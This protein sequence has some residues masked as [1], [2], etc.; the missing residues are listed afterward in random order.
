MFETRLR[1]IRKKQKLTLEDVAKRCTPPTTAQTI[2]RLETGMRTL[3]VNWIERIAGALKVDPQELIGIPEAGDIKVLAT[4][5]K[6]G[7][8]N[9][10]DELFSLR[11]SITNPVAVR[12]TGNIQGFIEDDM[13]ICSLMLPTQFKDAVGQDCLVI[14]EDK[15]AFG[16][17]LNY[18][19]VSAEVAVTKN[20]KA[21]VVTFKPTE[22][23]PYKYLIR[24]L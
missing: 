4:L 24:A 22:I 9:A 3:S 16:K 5:D 18:D 12:I 10:I 7:N 2:G 15:M 11:L 21:Q 8:I 1:E 6:K 19:G 20:S 14:E 23:A 17:L 13:L